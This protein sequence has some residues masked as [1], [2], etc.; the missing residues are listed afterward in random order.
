MRYPMLKGHAGPEAPR[1]EDDGQRHVE[2]VDPIV[3]RA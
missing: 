1:E 3:R 2:L